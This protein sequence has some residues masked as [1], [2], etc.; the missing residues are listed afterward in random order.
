MGWIGFIIALL[1][2][3]SLSAQAQDITLLRIAQFYPVKTLVSAA[4]AAAT[5]AA[6]VGLTN[7]PTG[8][9]DLKEL[10]LLGHRKPPAYRYK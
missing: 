10:K 7:T 5:I 8:A 4:H 6:L 9:R 3:P 2:Q 1:A